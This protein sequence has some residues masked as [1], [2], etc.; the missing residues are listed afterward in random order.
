MVFSPPVH[1]EPIELRVVVEQ[2]E[3]AF[4]QADAMMTAALA[5]PAD[6]DPVR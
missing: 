6:F 3:E 4:T 5:A 1:L 2:L